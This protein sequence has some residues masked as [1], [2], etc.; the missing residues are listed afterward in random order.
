MFDYQEKERERQNIETQ[1]MSMR[2][3]GVYLILGFSQHLFYMRSIM[4]R[5]IPLRCWM[6][7]D[8]N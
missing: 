5:E 2:L 8:L 4:I 7:E 3:V 6:N 1:D